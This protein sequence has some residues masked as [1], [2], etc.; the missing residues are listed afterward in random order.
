MIF[1]MLA[2]IV[3]MISS[4]VNQFGCQNKDYTCVNGYCTINGFCSCDAL[5]GGK[6]CDKPVNQGIKFLSEGDSVSSESLALA[7]AGYILFWYLGVMAI[8]AGIKFA[9]PI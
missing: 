3:G 9:I 8:V 4:R 6:Q 1:L 5:F 2:F 7:I